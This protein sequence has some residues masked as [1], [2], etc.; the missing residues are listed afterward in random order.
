MAFNR[1]PN[2]I[3]AVSVGLP[4]KHILINTCKL[5]ILDYIFLRTTQDMEL[6]TEH[7]CPQ[8]L[9]YMP[10][11]SYFLTKI[12]I[13]TR[14]LISPTKP[15]QNT[16]S[17]LQKLT[18]KGN[19]I[20]CFSLNRHIYDKEKQKYY[21][22]ILLELIEFV[23]YLIQQKYYIVFLPFNTS[24]I[25]EAHSNMEN[26]ILIHNDVFHSIKY[27][28]PQMIRQ[29]I[30]IDYRLSVEETIALYDFFYLTIPMRFHACLFSIYQHVP[31]IPLYTTKK[32]KTILL[33]I[34]W[35]THYELDKNEK[36]IPISMDKNTLISKV[37]YVIANHTKP[38]FIL[39]SLIL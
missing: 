38:L 34:Q 25:L 16:F 27:T 14:L 23:K 22:N 33:D 39:I 6:F 19:K 12:N 11:I 17:Q 24:D 15:F 10:D 26:D 8:R 29:I 32:M 2:K 30:N 9:F 5:S 7:F 3:I 36:D 35:E 18:K 13:N 21:E 28:H 20:I 4:Y 31:M 37:E 1:K